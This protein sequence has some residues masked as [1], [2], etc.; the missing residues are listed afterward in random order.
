MKLL[1]VS[2]LAHTGF[3]RVGRE[4]ARGLLDKGHD[5]RVIGINYRGIDGEL[6][7]V[8][9]RHMVDARL[10]DAIRE[11]M[12]D[13][14]ADPLT[15]R[16]IPASIAVNGRSH[17]FGHE[18]T[19]PAMHGQVWPNWHADAVLLVGD[20]EAVRLRL[21]DC[22]SGIAAKPVYNYVPIEGT[23]IPRS[24]D[25]IWRYTRP[26]A[27]SRFGQ[28]QLESLLGR[29]VPMIPHGASDAFHPVTATRPGHYRGKAIQSK[30]AAKDAFGL[31][32]RT[33]ILRLD[34]HIYRKNYAAFFRVM[35]PVLAAHPEVVCVIHARAQDEYGSLYDLISREPGAVN[36]DP[37]DTASWSHPQYLLTGMHDT[38]RGLSDVDLNVLYNAA[39]LLV[40]PT[41]AEGFGLTLLEA[42]ACGVPVVST[43]Y[44]AITEVVGPG[45]VLIPPAAF[46]TN[47]YAH[48]WALVDEPAMS[49][50]VERLIA[51]P[52]E[53]RE[54]G[55]VGQRHAARFTWSAAVDAF[56]A[57]LTQPAAVAA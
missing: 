8:I 56:D 48:E 47:Q 54:L 3:G 9:N 46:V 16:T 38:F 20:P 23:G 28:E 35:R 51:K 57:L 37:D 36:T 34:R 31:R 39:D 44:S 55:R 50:A 6:A 29:P 45:G 26:V 52:A 22:G 11:R 10:R 40:S 2:D 43:D 25:V 18:L 21:I 32:G 53:R 41:M 17:P 1:L 15:D 13:M 33:V 12:D 24:W 4:L 7:P 49:A 42:L 30:D 5:I 19:V 27:M 14:L